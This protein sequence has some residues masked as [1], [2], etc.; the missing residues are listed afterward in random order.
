MILG[1]LKLA[2]YTGIGLNQYYESVKDIKN[3]SSYVAQY[4][5]ARTLSRNE[6]LMG[7]FAVGCAGF[8]IGGCLGCAIDWRAGT[9]PVGTA[10]GAAAGAMIGGIVGY[11]AK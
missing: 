11:Y 5:P 4:V 10:L 6:K 9:F 7:G 3:V 2:Y 8:V 1:M